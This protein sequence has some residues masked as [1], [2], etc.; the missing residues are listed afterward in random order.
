MIK[1]YETRYDISLE[2]PF[3]CTLLRLLVLQMYRWK[4]YMYACDFV[5]KYEENV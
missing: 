2:R 1:V 5:C 3:V 4:L